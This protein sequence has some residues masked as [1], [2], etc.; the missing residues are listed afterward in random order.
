MSKQ[1]TATT[2]KPN[3]RLVWIYNE[4]ECVRQLTYSGRKI[5]LVQNTVEGRIGPKAEVQVVVLTPGLNRKP[6]SELSLCGY[7]ELEKLEHETQGKVRAIE[8][9]T[10]FSKYLAPKVVEGTVSKTALQAWLDLEKREEVRTM[11]D[12]QLQSRKVK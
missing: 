1:A 7:Q 4:D 9:P 6:Y 8:A 3:D 11:I 5:G 12:K 10:A 2:D